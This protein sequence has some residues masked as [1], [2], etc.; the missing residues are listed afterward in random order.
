[1][2]CIPIGHHDCE[3]PVSPD[4]LPTAAG[5]PTVQNSTAPDSD[6]TMPK[7]IRHHRSQVKSKI[8]NG[9]LHPLYLFPATNTDAQ[10]Q[11]TQIICPHT[12]YQRHMINSKTVNPEP[13]FPRASSQRDALPLA[14]LNLEHTHGAQRRP[15]GRPSTTVALSCSPCH[16]T[17]VTTTYG[18]HHTYSYASA[19]FRPRPF[20]CA[21]R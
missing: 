5:Q 4:L 19:E 10:S 9:L 12:N 2:L 18:V 21:A 13:S 8:F 7:M 16:E 6:S 20:A 17:L 3:L 14:S 15:Q 11:Q 1:M